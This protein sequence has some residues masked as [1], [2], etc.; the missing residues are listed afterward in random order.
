MT[1]PRLWQSIASHG[2]MINAWTGVSHEAAQEIIPFIRS[3]YPG[4]QRFAS[5]ADEK[6]VERF[7]LLGVRGIVDRGFPPGLD[8]TAAILRALNVDGDAIDN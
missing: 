7:N 6:D 4:L 3:L 8:F 1:D 2:R 5:V